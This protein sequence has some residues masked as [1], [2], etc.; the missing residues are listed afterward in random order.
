MELREEVKIEESKRSSVPSQPSYELKPEAEIKVLPHSDD[1]S[2]LHSG[3]Q[4]SDLTQEIL[5]KRCDE[6]FTEAPL[7]FKARKAN[8]ME[9]QI[10]KMIKKYKITIPIVN[11]R[12]QL[13]LVGA[14][15][16]NLEYK[17]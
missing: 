5:E 15:K 16:L 17:F 4:D 1:S 6:F 9:E 13:Y 7:K 3:V 14:Q 10:S 2:W 8:K 11:V 12:P